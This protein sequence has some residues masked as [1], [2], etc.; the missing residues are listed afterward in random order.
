[1]PST[2]LYPYC[3]LD[4]FGTI[5]YIGTTNIHN[6]LTNLNNQV[7]ERISHAWKKVEIFVILKINK[8]FFKTNT[9]KGF[10]NRPSVYK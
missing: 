10:I 5:S 9:Y 2:I 6:I 3:H 4:I 1:M 8:I 7:L